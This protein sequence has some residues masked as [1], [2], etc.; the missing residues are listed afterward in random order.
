MVLALYYHYYYYNT[1]TTTSVTSF[2]RAK[3]WAQLPRINVYAF[4]TYMED[5]IG[6]IVRRSAGVL[7]C[8]ETC[9]RTGHSDT[10]TTSTATAA[11]PTTTTSTTA[12][13]AGHV[14]EGHIVRD[15]APKKVM[16]CLTFTLPAEVSP[17]CYTAT[18]TTTSAEIYLFY[19][20]FTQNIYIH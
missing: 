3:A 16:I 5:P 7:R 20:Y 11:T 19:V 1:N 17:C 8:S 18:T 10:A 4:S 12:V 13:V 15:V 14:C 2:H 6:D 9:L